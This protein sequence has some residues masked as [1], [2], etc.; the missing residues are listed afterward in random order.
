MTHKGHLKRLRKGL[1]STNIYSVLETDDIE[2]DA[3]DSAS[4]DDQFTD[5]E[6][7]SIDSSAALLDARPIYSKM[8]DIS[9]LTPDEKKLYS[10]HSDATGEFPFESYEGNK[11][12]LVS[13][14]LNYI[15]VEP[16]KDRSAPSYVKAYRATIDFYKSFGYPI[17]LQ[18]LDN[19]SSELLETYFKNEARIPFQYI[20][21][22]NK[23]ANKAERAIQSF[24]NHLIASVASANSDFPPALWDK[25]LFQLELTLAHL[26]PFTLNPD[27]SSYEGMFGK[28]FDFLSN[29]IAPV[30]TKVLIYVPPDLRSSW[31][32]HGLEGFYLRPSTDHYRNVHCFIPSTGG[33]WD[34]D[35]IA[36]FPDKY[37]MPGGSKE[38]IL[39]EAANDLKAAITNNSSPQNINL[40]AADLA[41]AIK[42]IGSAR[43]VSYTHLTLS[44]KRIV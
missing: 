40:I 8:V 13:V 20:S 37:T 11:F 18:R 42:N 21:P 9:N 14:F 33:F 17:S 34:T 27:I 3:V 28:K 30:G 5:S 19:E 36:Y 29:P 31:D 41:D 43:T 32:N 2:E 39:V 10:L 1:R 22:N 26:R 35:Q 15:H 25:L 6:A 4:D 24:K 44:T 12:I 7:E 23:R 16:L 38:E